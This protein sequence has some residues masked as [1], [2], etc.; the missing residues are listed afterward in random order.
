MDFG[1]RENRCGSRFMPAAEDGFAR[2]R[3]RTVPDV[4]Q[5]QTRAE[6]PALLLKV[7]FVGE[8]FRRVLPQRRKDALADRQ[9]TERV[10]ETRMLGGW[11]REIRKPELP[12][13]AQAL[14]RD[15]ADEPHLAVVELDEPVNRIEDPLQTCV[16][17]PGFITTTRVFG[18]MRDIS[19]LN[20]SPA[21]GPM[22]R[23]VVRVVYRNCNRRT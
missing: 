20:R 23:S 19:A 22:T 4:V 9:R 18:E 3:E 11:K 14:K 5:K 21:S 6:Q 7:S 13:P 16:V 15:Q 1:K 2:M 12:Q 10:R 8:E 17:S